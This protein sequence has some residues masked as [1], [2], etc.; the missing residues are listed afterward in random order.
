METL[1]MKKGTKGNGRSTESL[2]RSSYEH[3]IY[4]HG[5]TER[6]KIWVD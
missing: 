6:L 1:T 4:I 3:E 5:H 2:C